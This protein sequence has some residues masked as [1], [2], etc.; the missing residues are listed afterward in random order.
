MKSECGVRTERAYSTT[1]DTKPWRQNV[2]ETLLILPNVE[3]GK[4]FSKAQKQTKEVVGCGRGHH[5]LCK[6]RTSVAD[7]GPAEK[8]DRN[9]NRIHPHF[10]T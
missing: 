5:P 7:A 6:S 3:R 1:V 10:S 4:V 2:V 9:T 8:V